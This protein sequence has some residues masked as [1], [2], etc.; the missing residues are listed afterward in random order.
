MSNWG[1]TQFR[2]FSKT[3]LDDFLNLKITSLNGIFIE[4]VYEYKPPGINNKLTF[5]THIKVLLIEVVE[6][7]LLL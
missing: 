7:Q 3:R 6:G 2:L 1:K 4:Q 5:K